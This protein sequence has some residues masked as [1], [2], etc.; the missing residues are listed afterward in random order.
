MDV[1]V[2]MLIPSFASEAGSTEDG[3][4]IDA[5]HGDIVYLAQGM[6]D[7]ATHRRA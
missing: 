3:V 7:M 2:P 6:L 1:S 4:P 5:F